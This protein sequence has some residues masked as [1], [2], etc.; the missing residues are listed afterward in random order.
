[1]DTNIK[2]VY[3][4]WRMGESNNFEDVF[5]ALSAAVHRSQHIHEMHYVYVLYED[6]FLEMI[7]F[8]KGRYTETRQSDRKK[9]K[10]NKPGCPAVRVYGNHRRINVEK[11]LEIGT[12]SPYIGAPGQF[13]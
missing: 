9:K 7:T 10:D 12:D 1:M 11:V 6:G 13:E 5:A 2:S 3:C 4:G 8:Y